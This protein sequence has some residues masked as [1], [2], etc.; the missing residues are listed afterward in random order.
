MTVLVLDLDGVVVVGHPEGGR[1]DKD[2]QR[3]FG[4]KPEHLQQ[5]FFQAHWKRIEIGEADLFDVLGEV[6]PTLEC[7]GDPHAFVEYWFA[8]D[9]RLDSDVLAE[10]DAWR[11]GGRKAYLATVQEH[12]RAKY[13]W[14]TLALRDHF[15]GMLYS[16]ALGAKKP[17]AAFFERALAKLPGVAAQDIVFLDDRQDNV[18]TAAACGWRAH[19]HRDVEDLRRALT[20]KPLR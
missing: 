3:D 5:R 20:D 19:L 16:A 14:E 4:L 13:I 18:D 8:N 1:W 6:W 10:V 12:H 7:R 9:S 17:H 2:V 11:A 15:D